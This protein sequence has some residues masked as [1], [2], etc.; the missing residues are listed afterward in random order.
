MITSYSA[1]GFYFSLVGYCQDIFFSFRNRGGNSLYIT[2][3]HLPKQLG[4]HA[5]F[6]LFLKKCFELK[7]LYLLIS[8]TTYILER[9]KQKYNREICLSPQ[10]CNCPRDKSYIL[11]NSRACTEPSSCVP[12]AAFYGK[13]IPDIR[14][15]QKDIQ[16]NSELINHE[17]TDAW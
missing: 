15:L 14:C 2:K 17:G 5:I 1:L 4:K 12:V 7:H 6:I 3:S 9:E 16:H 11:I 8:L 10:L 13:A